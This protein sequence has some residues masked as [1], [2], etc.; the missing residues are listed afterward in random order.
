[1]IIVFHN[2][3][4]GNNIPVRLDNILAK[5]QIY[6][7]LSAIAAGIE[8]GMNLVE[9]SRALTNF[10]S[11]CGRMNLIQGIKNSLLIDD[12]Y[13]ASPVSTGAAIE[14]MGE[15]DSNRKIVVLGD[16][17]ELGE[18]TEEGHEKIAKKF[19]EIKGDIF[20]AVGTRMQF[21]VSELIKNNFNESNIFSFRNSLEAGKKLQEILQEGDLVL[22]K[23]SQGARMEKVVEEVMA[24]PEKANQ[25]LCRQDSKWKNIPVKN[26]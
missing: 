18:E 17:L 12:T 25:L 6:A 11:P 5:H 13:N 4:D 16:M 26:L 10:S 23:G 19:L 15:I 8:M 14:T 20:L 22:I 3:Y 9:A 1:L 7:A 21:A 24:Q 2:S